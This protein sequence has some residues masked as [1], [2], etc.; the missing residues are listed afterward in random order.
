MKELGT[1]FG[2]KMYLETEDEK[3]F[4]SA[5]K[6]LEAK[7]AYKKKTDEEYREE[8]MSAYPLRKPNRFL[9]LAI[10]FITLGL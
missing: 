7:F 8:I 10:S 3:V 4:D 5:L 2:A 6:H 1:L 9:A